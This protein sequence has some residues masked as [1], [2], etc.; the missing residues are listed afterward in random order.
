MNGP[1]DAIVI[2][3][4]AAGLFCAA[5]AGRRGRRVLVLDHADKIGR[6]ILISGGGRCNFTNRGATH[7]NYVS[8]NPHFARSALARYRPEDFIAL[9]EKHGIPY[10]ERRHGQLFCDDSAK[11]IVALL[12]DECTAAGVEVRTG[13]R[14]EGV[15]HAGGF[16]VGTSHG[17]LQAA[18]VVLATG[19][20]S[21]PTTGATD[22]GHRIAR[23]F[24]LRVTPLV[25]GLVPF[26][27]D[28]RLGLGELSGIAVDAR[29][30]CGRMA[31]QENLL[32]THGGVS[33]PSV[34]QVSNIWDPGAEVTVDLLPDADATE[35][36]AGARAAG[37]RAQAATLLAERLPKRLVQLRLAGLPRD[38]GARPAADLANADIQAM[39]DALQAW[40]LVPTGTEGYRKAEVTRGGIDTRDLSSQTMEA[41]TVP[42]LH[43]IG[44]VVDVTGWLGGYNFQWAWASGHA[45]GMAL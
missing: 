41:R 8:A 17:P 4:G 44:E 29:L 31:F 24:G 1:W 9:V 18:K 39:R 32:F 42:G 3:G 40:T 26:T 5:T 19:G 6:K 37:S 2:G 34:L 13:V 28:A 20:L 25:P 10:H 12:L 22:L 27:T 7:A 35:L 16:T 21:V 36:L 43:A 14:I 33:G 30:A 23:R 11:R 45:A 15:D 38:P